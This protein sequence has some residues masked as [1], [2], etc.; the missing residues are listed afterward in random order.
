MD[1]LNRTDLTPQI[2]NAIQAT[3]RLH[4]RQRMWFLE[5][6][7]ALVA[8][9]S[10]ETIALPSNFIF[11]Q[12]LLVVQDSANIRLVPNAFDMIR[13]LNINNTVG[14]PTRYCLY[15]TNIHFANIPDSAYPIPCYYLKQLPPLSAPADTNDW[16][17]AASDLV[18]YGATKLVYQTVIRN[19]S[20]AAVFAQLEATHLLELQREG[21]QH[22]TLMIRATRF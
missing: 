14:L 21:Q 5:T 2:Q 11:M 19:M 10:V 1:F 15:G 9:P 7:T 16:L 13:W 17:S 20:A 18:V 4:Q 22:Q 6:S 8:V 12:E 3:I